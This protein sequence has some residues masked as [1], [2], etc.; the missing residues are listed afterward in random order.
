MAKSSTPPRSRPRWATY[1]RG[2]Q[3]QRGVKNSTEQ[4]FYDEHL[5]PMLQDQSAR[6]VWYERWSWTLTEKT[7]GG[8]PGLRYTPDFVVILA[9]GELRAYEVKGV[10]NARR[11][12]L[13]RVKLFADLI[14]IRIFVATQLTKKN[15]GGFK[16]AEY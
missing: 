10:G 7:P 4:K 1:A 11:Q 12:D 15:G 8:L 5:V 13:N 6:A 16:I 2:A 14:P 3:K 9:S